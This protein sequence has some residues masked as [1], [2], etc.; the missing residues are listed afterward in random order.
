MSAPRKFLGDPLLMAYAAEIRAGAVGSWEF[1]QPENSDILSGAAM[2]KDAQ[3]LAEGDVIATKAI[4]RILDRKPRGRKS[5]AL[6]RTLTVEPG[7]VYTA[8]YEFQPDYPAVV[9][10]EGDEQGRFG[11]SVRDQAGMPVCHQQNP[12]PRK[13]CRWS[14]DDLSTYNLELENQT[15]SP[16]EF[17]VITN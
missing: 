16:Q 6:I 4:Q 8:N 14:P 1:D 3:Y 10:V 15:L 17:L 12:K 5:G 9:Y 2:M 11:V 13:I 7:A